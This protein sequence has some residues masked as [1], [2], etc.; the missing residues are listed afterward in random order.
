ME[1]TDIGPTAIR[2]GRLAASANGHA[3]TVTLAYDARH[4]RRGMMRTDGGEDFLLDLPEAAELRDGAVLVLEDGRHV[5]IR[6]AP[7]PLTE[8]RAECPR[9]LARLA[10]HLGNRHLPVE[11]REGRLLIKP[12][13]VIEHMLLGLDARLSPVNAPFHPEG[14]AYGHGR[15]HGHSH[16]PHHDHDAHSRHG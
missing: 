8:I 7:E 9:H 1:L 11:V 14:G 5:L 4:R 16:D 3:D 12:D 2:A 15:V 10:W 6:A 13:H